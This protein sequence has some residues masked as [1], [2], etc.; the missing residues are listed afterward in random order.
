MN[1][2]RLVSLLGLAVVVVLFAL[3]ACRV[4]EVTTD[5]PPYFDTTPLICGSPE[6]PD[7]VRFLT[8]REVTRRFES[9]TGEALSHHAWLDVPDA[10]VFLTT[11]DST[12]GEHS[13]ISISV[14]ARDCPGGV[15]WLLADNKTPGPG[16]LAWELTS[17]YFGDCWSG[18][19]RYPR[20]N[21]V[22]IWRGVSCDQRVNRRWTR[23]DRVLTEMTSRP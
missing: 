10:R 12:L 15:S 6:W 17:G 7:R 2:A 11:S 3:T 13:E 5:L 23:F 9:M 4:G 18:G 19:K 14:L 21:L 20:S 1:R 22:V 8:A 16:G